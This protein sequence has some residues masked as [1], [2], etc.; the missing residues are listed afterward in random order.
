[1]SG[2]PRIALTMGDP[3]GI[4]PEIAVRAAVLSKYRNNAEII[5][6]GCPDII[7]AA[8]EKFN[9]GKY[10]LIHQTGELKMAEV[11]VGKANPSCG[12]AAMDAVIAA[13]RDALSGKVD[14]IV[15]CPMNK[16]SV[17]LAGVKFT[18]HTELIAELCNC[19]NYAMMQSAGNLRVAFVTTHI[20]LKDAAAAVTAERIIEVAELLNNVIKSEGIPCPLLAAAAINPH[21]GEN[22]YMGC[23]DE[24]VVKPALRRLREQGINIEGPFPPD[25]LFIE[26]I[27]TRF[28]GILSMY[29]DQGHIPFK[30]LAFDRGVNST[31]G[32]PVIRTS[33]DH[34]TAFEIAWQGIADTGSLEAALSLAIVR[35]GQQK[36]K[37]I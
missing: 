23:E 20:P 28:D 9:G 7:N 33:V 2:I 16:A 12:L 5:I 34:G 3:A 26:N 31:P 1:M 29:H 32:L 14:A 19:Q 21:A 6:Y 25:T 8:A 37:T 10:P 30:M 24:E 4:G 11:T 15:T 35:S 18:G 13:T 17:N 36:R 22:G 27:R